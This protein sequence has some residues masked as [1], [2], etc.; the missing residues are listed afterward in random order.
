MQPSGIQQLW[1]F[2]LAAKQARRKMNH[3]RFSDTKVV[4]TS[5]LN[6]WLAWF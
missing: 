4:L 6:E 2:A 1:L 5:L 3:A